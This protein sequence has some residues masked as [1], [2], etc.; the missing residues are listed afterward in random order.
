MQ[1]LIDFSLKQKYS[2]VKKLRSSLEDMKK[3]MNWEAF[4]PLFPEKETNK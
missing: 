1:N 4:L 3:L 2:E